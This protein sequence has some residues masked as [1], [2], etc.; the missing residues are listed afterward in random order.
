MKIGDRVG[1]TGKANRWGKVIGS[2]SLVAYGEI[3]NV[4]LVELDKGFYDPTETCYV[5]IL[6]CDE[7]NLYLL[8]KRYLLEET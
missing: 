5:T 1:L 6:T 7:S 3:R 2:G 4:L 8:D